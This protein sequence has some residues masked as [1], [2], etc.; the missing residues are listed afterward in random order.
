ML[1]RNER[2]QKR[3]QPRL[4][5]RHI[6]PDDQGPPRCRQDA[7]HHRHAELAVPCWCILRPPRPGTRRPLRNLVTPKPPSPP[8]LRTRAAGRVRPSRDDRE[9]QWAGTEAERA[10]DWSFG[11]WTAFAPFANDNAKRYVQYGVLSCWRASCPVLHRQPGE[12][13]RKEQRPHDW[14]E[15]L[16]DRHGPNCLSKRQRGHHRFP[17]SSSDTRLVNSCP[18]SST[19]RCFHLHEFGIASPPAASD[20]S[21]ASAPGRLIRQLRHHVLDPCFAC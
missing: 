12:R 16:P 8:D 21:A 9:E 7:H 11:S 13:T 3:C 14:M 4:L 5:Q 20:P 10:T 2:V 6:P 18:T 15:L 19:P 1:S 17:H